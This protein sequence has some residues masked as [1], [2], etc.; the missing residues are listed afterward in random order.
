MSGPVVRALTSADWQALRAL[1]LLALRTEPGVFSA[2]YTAVEAEP[3]EFWQARATGE[4]HQVFAAFAGP[5]MVGLIGVF[6]WNEDP[7]G[8]TGF[9]G[10]LFVKASH[11]GQG[12]STAL[13]SAALDW[14]RARPKFRRAV[15]GHRASNRASQRAILRQGFR[16]V[17]RQSHTWPDGAVED[18]IGYVL[19]LKKSPDGTTGGA[20]AVIAGSEIRF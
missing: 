7:T 19:G 2:D 16:Q 4:D 9:I 18:E 1:R 13:F 17:R 20:A 3:P 10:M 14:L 5:A 15:V 6:T 11:R 12:I 8:V